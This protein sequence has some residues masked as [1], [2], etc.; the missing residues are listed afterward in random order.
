MAAELAGGE[1][2]DGLVGLERMTFC[3]SHP[4]TPSGP[5]RAGS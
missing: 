3:R 1:A 5:G 2:A 4:L